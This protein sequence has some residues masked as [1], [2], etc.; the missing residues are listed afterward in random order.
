MRHVPNSY[1]SRFWFGR[2]GTASGQ[3]RPGWS[4]LIA[5]GVAAIAILGIILTLVDAS[6]LPDLRLTSIQLDVKT[7]G[8]GDSFEITDQVK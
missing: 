8:A 7:I 6:H 1:E 5:F 4:T 2:L 3:Q